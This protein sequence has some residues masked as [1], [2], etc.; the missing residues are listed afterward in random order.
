[1]IT[2][3]IGEDSK[4]SDTMLKIE[5]LFICRRMSNGENREIKQQGRKKTNIIKIERRKNY[6]RVQEG[7]IYISFFI[8]ILVY[9][10]LGVFL[11][12]LTLPLKLG[13]DDI[14]SLFIN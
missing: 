10:L 8:F 13:M 5:D 1:M 6:R 11:V 14:P 3:G 9:E 12:L 2:N 7:V 4:A